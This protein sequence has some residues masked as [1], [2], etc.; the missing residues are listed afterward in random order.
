MNEATKLLE[1]ARGIESRI[2][3]TRENAIH[4]GRRL[5]ALLARKE[6]DQTIRDADLRAARK[7]LAQAKQEQEEVI[8]LKDAI[9]ELL[10]AAR[11]KAQSDNRALALEAQAV[12][13]RAYE[14]AK[15][16]LDSDL[17]SLNRDQTRA[18][19]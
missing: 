3:D 14:D 4:A 18:R 15:A 10:A 11:E 6:V 12:S 2:L 13:I 5:G 19:A 8:L 16:K 9:P 7:A 17:R 1:I